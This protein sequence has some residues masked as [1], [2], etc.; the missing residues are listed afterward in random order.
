M[1]MK[2]SDKSNEKE[3]RALASSIGICYDSEKTK[4]GW[5]LDQCASAQLPTDWIKEYD[6]QGD[7][8][9]FNNKDQRISKVHPCIS[10]FRAFFTQFVE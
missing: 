4:Y 6:P 10:K 3:L 9:Y 8:Y 7:I 5:Y 1:I 2:E